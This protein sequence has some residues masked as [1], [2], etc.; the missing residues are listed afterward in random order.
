[1]R[2]PKVIYLAIVLM[3]A[4]SGYLAYNLFYVVGIN[5]ASVINLP[6]KTSA[7]IFT[8]EFAAFQSI[9]TIEA[10]KLYQEIKTQLKENDCLGVG[11]TNELFFVVQT[12]RDKSIVLDNWITTVKGKYSILSKEPVS[13]EK[14][15][16]YKLQSSNASK[17]FDGVFAHKGALKQFNM[18]YTNN[19]FTISYCENIE[20]AYINKIPFSLIPIKANYTVNLTQELAKSNDFYAGFNSTSYTVITTDTCEIIY[21]PD[22]RAE[23]YILDSNSTF[24]SNFYLKSTTLNQWPHFVHIDG[25]S[26]FA[27]KRKILIEIIDG[28]S[29]KK[30]LSELESMQKW[31]MEQINNPSLTISKHEIDN[32]ILDL[33]FNKDQ[34]QVIQ[35]SQSI[36]K[37]QHYSLKLSSGEFHQKNSNPEILI[38]LAGEPRLKPFVFVSHLGKSKY[39][40]TQDEYGICYLLNNKGKI[41]WKK[42]LRHQIIG[43][44]E[45]I[46]LYANNKVQLLLTTKNQVYILDIKG[47]TPSG[48]PI[49]LKDETQIQASLFDY[50]NNGQCRIMV[51]L[52]NGMVQNFNS[53]GSEVQGW[54]FEKTEGYPTTK[55]KHFKL[56]DTDYLTHC[57]SKNKALFYNRKGLGKLDP[58]SLPNYLG[59]KVLIL[60]SGEDIKNTIILYR[61]GHNNLI[62]KKLNN[63]IDSL[64][65]TQKIKKIFAYQDVDGDGKKEIIC[66]TENGIISVS[67]NG[68][69][70]SEFKTSLDL[71]EQPSYLYFS[72]NK[73]LLGLIS[74][75]KIY[76]INE[77]GEIEDGYPKEGNNVFSVSN[78]DNTKEFHII[79]GKNKGLA[80]YPI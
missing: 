53:K 26:L 52:K 48:F 27:K 38:K 56:G 79:V 33:L 68:I 17:L 18:L 1:M 3:A 76:L 50:D 28:L 8:K 16:V 71:K 45:L 29:T 64:I 49:N 2:T 5:N 47:N 74:S 34:S 21:D 31:K 19:D 65:L 43:T 30:N 73:I 7:F 44:P 51:A 78:L 24:Y 75:N 46:D 70:T 10:N 23:E 66:K 55:I 35:L 60:P 13:F 14:K 15:L 37:T 9:P 11:R 42:D 67:T 69:I 77:F 12:K 41:I 39:I 54:K 6:D 61:S 22:Y 40:F 36:G 25:F 20:Q 57:T 32:P 4:L 72:K 59:G 63:Q 58:V 80:L 62:K